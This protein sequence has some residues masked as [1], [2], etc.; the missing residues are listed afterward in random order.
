[1]AQND[2]YASR[3]KPC[4][5]PAEPG[6]WLTSKSQPRDAVAVEPETDAQYWLGSR[7]AAANDNNVDRRWKGEANYGPDSDYLARKATP[8]ATRDYE[9]DIFSRLVAEGDVEAAFVLRSIGQLTAPTGMMAANDNF[10]EGAD[11]EMGDG[12]GLDYA[13]EQPKAE[14]VI[15]DY[16]ENDK[17]SGG[18]FTFRQ[19]SGAGGCKLTAAHRKD[20]R[21]GLH[22]DRYLVLRG[23]AEPPRQEYFSDGTTP[24]RSHAPKNAAAAAELA[25]ACER[26]ELTGWQRVTWTRYAALGARVYGDLS[27]FSTAKG[28]GECGTAAPEHGVIQEIRRGD[29]EKEFRKR[30]SERSLRLID[31]AISRCT[32]TEI[33]EAADLSRNGVKKA[34]KAALKEA[35]SVVT[36]ITGE[37]MPERRDN[38][39]A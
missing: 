33:A 28:V 8:G 27:I 20:M 36:E 5:W 16:V 32:Y 9:G 37:K 3:G 1:M 6:N 11:V 2:N 4:T 13:L 39:A 31:A 30:M 34:V 23:V 24:W 15:E 12:F 38:I 26:T 29:A 35:W 19:R 7:Y 14:K 10:A 22:V 21:E 18:W 17:L 25:A